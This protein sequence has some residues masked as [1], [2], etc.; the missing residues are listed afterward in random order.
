VTLNILWQLK[1]TLIRNNKKMKN[2]LVILLLSLPVYLFNSVPLKS[3]QLVQ[4]NKEN[5]SKCS[6]SQSIIRF[7]DSSIE[8]IILHPEDVL[9]NPDAFWA[10][11]SAYQ[12]VKLWHQRVSFPIPMEQWKGWMQSFKNLP[13]EDREK[14]SQLIAA[15]TTLKN[16]KEFNEKAIPYICSFLPK[17]FPDI[18]TTIYFT[19]AIMASGFQSGNSIVI[20]GANADKD[21]LLIHELFHQGFDKCK[22][23]RIESS[24]QDSVIFQI[25]NDLQNEGM[26]TYVGYKGLKEFPHCRTDLLKDDYK[27]FENPEEINA[28]LNKMNELFKKSFTLKEKELKDTLWQIGSIDRAYYVVGCFMARTIDEK[29]GRNALVE[30]I[31]S[32]PKSFLRTYN[33]LVEGKL[34]VFD[35]YTQK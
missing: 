35:L 5:K 31:S 15:R 24:S 17:D 14:N 20:Y 30:T 19:T 18:C 25:Y 1:F 3:Q 8:K 29:L 34:R 12:L 32:G 21:N 27:L 16:G 4:E 9:A 13:V 7:D 22:P 23:K 26:A 6:S 2:T 11:D 28:L 33:S 10:S